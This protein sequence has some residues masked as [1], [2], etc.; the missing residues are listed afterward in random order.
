MFRRLTKFLEKHNILNETQFG[1]KCNRS[2]I[3]AIIVIADKIQRTIAN[4]KIPCGLFLDLSKAFDTVDH[5][6]LIKNLEYYGIRGTAC[7]WFRSHLHNTE[8][9]YWKLIV[10]GTNRYVR[11][12]LGLS[13][14]SPF[15]FAIFKRF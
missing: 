12:F 4:K 3:Q 14:W 2:T 11:G 6:I 5:S 10:Q 8:C 7:D 13:S 15:I 9:H 1:F